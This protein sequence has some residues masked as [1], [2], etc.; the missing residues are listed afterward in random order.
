MPSLASYGN[1]LSH[2]GVNLHMQPQNLSGTND[3]ILIKSNSGQTFLRF[4]SSNEKTKRAPGRKL[5]VWAIWIS[6][7]NRSKRSCASGSYRMALQLLPL[8]SNRSSS[9][10][11][12][13]CVTSLP[14]LPVPLKDLHLWNWGE[15]DGWEKLMEVLANW[16]THQEKSISSQ[17]YC[18]F[19][20]AQH[21][22][23][24]LSVWRC[25]LIPFKGKWLTIVWKAVSFDNWKC[26]FSTRQSNIIHTI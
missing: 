5:I 12:Q 10:N 19:W 3:L 21:L 8:L 26:H 25:I 7:I 17:T 11:S 23:K 16:R 20:F 2:M 18:D 22:T 15:R 6:K 24:C 1:G 4:N 9:H 14:L 13:C